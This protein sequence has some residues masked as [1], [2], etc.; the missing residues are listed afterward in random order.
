MNGTNE[1]ARL[2]TAPGRVNLIG[3]HTDYNLLPVFPVALQRKVKIRFRPRTD[4]KV[5]LRSANPAFGEREFELAPSIPAYEGGDWGNYAKAAAQA[6]VGRWGIRRGLDGE[7]GGDL[8]MSAGLSSSS[9]LVVAS[10][11]ALLDANGVEFDRVELAEL[12]A[13]GEHYVGTEGGGM[14][15]AACI[16]GVRGHAVLIEFAPLR[17]NPVP[18]PAGWRFLIAHSL[19]TANKSGEA[20][21]EYNL[22]VRSCRAAYAALGLDPKTARERNPEELIARAEQ[23]L[24]QPVLGCFRHVVSEGARV[25]KARRALLD[26]DPRTFGHLM[27]ASHASL[28]D[29]YR[30]SHPVVDRLVEIAMKAGALGARVTGAGFGGFVVVLAEAARAEVIAEGIVRDFYGTRESQVLLVEPS[31][32]ARVQ[33]A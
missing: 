13:R 4:G 9:A 25:W 12:M 15:Q 28:R 32:G 19:V 20:R 10:A 29:D 16:G 27:L 5:R 3:E 7:V 21:D 31:E 17:L 30:V 22:R 11:M 8:P 18:V 14:D 6:L 24:E 2:A 26:D 23:S 33:D 1:K